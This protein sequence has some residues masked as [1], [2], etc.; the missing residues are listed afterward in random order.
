MAE[1]FLSF[2]P[3][4]ISEDEI[5]EVVE[6]LRSGWLTTGPRVQ[7]F[8]AEFAELTG[9]PCA[10]ALNSGTA[11]LHL[12]IAA[13]HIGPG[14]VVITT[15]LTFCACVNVI[16]QQGATPVLADICEDDLNLDPEQVERWIT[17]A[18]RAIL[19]VDYGGQPARLGEL[20]RLADAHGLLLLEDA[21][22]AVGARYGGVPVG[23]IAD[24]TAFSFYATKNLTTG[25]G[26]M[27]T[28]L[29]PEL[30]AEARV[31]S[32]HGMSRDAWRRYQ[33]GGSWAYDVVAPG[34]KYNMSDMQAALGLVQ[35]RRLEELNSRREAIAA[36][37]HEALSGCE[38]VM[39]PDTRPEVRHVWQLYALRLRLESL[40]ID[41]ARFIEALTER[42]IGSSVHFIPIHHHSYYREG[43]GFSPADLP[44]TER[45]FPELLSLPIHPSMTDADVDR[46]ADAVQSIAREHGRSID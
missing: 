30:D 13:A 44:V 2:A 28:S 33:Q 36:H 37:Y 1:S 45:V 21:A 15:P 14:D 23:A 8:E 25:E 12:A 18:T 4:A 43:F 27:L 26:G 10:L 29:E 5:A 40:R 35:L 38:H 39:L 42:G 17:P 46:V 6:T 32:L 9:S 16:V 34:F 7:R 3:P 20:K 11:A 41:R 24:A 22:H 19:A 31:L